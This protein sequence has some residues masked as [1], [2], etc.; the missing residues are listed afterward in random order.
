MKTLEK[1]A[2]TIHLMVFRIQNAAMNT[3][4]DI[5]VLRTSFK[6]SRF[7]MMYFLQNTAIN[8]AKQNENTFL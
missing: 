1:L 5:D 8:K 2:E 3:S 7:L 6:M 4:A